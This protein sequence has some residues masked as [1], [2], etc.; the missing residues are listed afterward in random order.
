MP[1]RKRDRVDLML[2]NAEGMMVIT[3]YGRNSN[4]VGPH[5]DAL[6]TQGVTHEYGSKFTLKM[7][8]VPSKWVSIWP[9]KCSPSFLIM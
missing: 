7:K 1:L 4:L 3:E 8:L 9:S 2:P 6:S 5:A